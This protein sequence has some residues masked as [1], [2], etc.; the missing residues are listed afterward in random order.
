[1][2]THK[3]IQQNNHITNTQIRLL[4]VD[5]DRDIVESLQDVLELERDDYIIKTAYDIKSATILSESF[6]PDIALLDIKLAN[7]SGLDLISPLRDANAN[8]TCI[9]MT[10]FRDVEY[11]VTAIRKGADDFLYKPLEPRNLIK[12]LK[13]FELNQI[14]LQSK[15]E[16]ERRFRAIFEQSFQFLF[17]LDQSGIIQEINTTALSFMEQDKNSLIGTHFAKAPWWNDKD[18]VNDAIKQTILGNIVR[19]ELSVRHQDKDY[20]FD[21]TFKPVTDSAG[22]IAIIIPEGRDVSE[23]KEYENNIT[24]LNRSL[25]KRVD[26][27]TEQLKA[28]KSLADSANQAKTEFLSQMSHELRTPLNA[29]IGFSQI[30][31]MG[32]HSNLTKA[33]LENI[34]HI[35][36]AG[37]HL[38]SLINQTLDLSHIDSG[39]IELKFVELDVHRVLEKIISITEPLFDNKSISLT[40]NFSAASFPTVYADEQALTQVLINL[41]SNAIKYNTDNGSIAIDA[42]VV[43]PGFLRVSITDSGQGVPLE[44]YDTI[45]DPFTRATNVMAIEGSGVGLSLCKKLIELMDGNIGFT[46]V[47]SEGSIFWIDIPLSN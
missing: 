12:T 17:I 22:E 42:Q 19:K 44:L 46:S 3:A 5:D 2:N 40:N 7:E 47:V 38:L 18:A 21:Y 16:T 31:T 36:Q 6:H 45:F 27:R 15:T 43:K 20:T 35:Q 32:D 9:M 1:M 24:T 13:R 30:L 28:A 25:E 29:I 8:I 10:A 39:L 11:A 4:I 23:Q 34:S 41:L 14:L 26:D 37:S 33:Q